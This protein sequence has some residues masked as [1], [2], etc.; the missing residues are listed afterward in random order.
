M[1]AFHLTSSKE[2]L[3]YE[4]ETYVIEFYLLLYITFS[5]YLLAALGLH[6]CQQAFCSYSKW[7]LLF[8]MRNRLL[9]VVVLLQNTV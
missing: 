5:I 7:E 9:I 2:S 8:V 1:S 6:C 4:E 3:T